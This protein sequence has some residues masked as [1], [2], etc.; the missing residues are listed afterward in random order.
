MTFS[1]HNEAVLLGISLQ[2]NIFLSQMLRFF[3]R[4]ET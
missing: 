4:L 3:E 1:Y 2:Y